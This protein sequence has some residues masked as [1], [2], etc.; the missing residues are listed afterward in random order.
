MCPRS[1]DLL[2]RTV[3]IPINQRMSDAHVASCASALR[4]VYHQ[5]KRGA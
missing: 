1:I 5:R 4:K 3:I 2:S